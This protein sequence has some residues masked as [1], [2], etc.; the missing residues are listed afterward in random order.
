M[1]KH[2]IDDIAAQAKSGYESVQKSLDDFYDT[3]TGR[4]LIDAGVKVENNAKQAYHDCKVGTERVSSKYG[5]AT[6]DVWNLGDVELEHISKL[7]DR[8]ADTIDDSCPSLARKTR[9]AADGLASYKHDISTLYILP[10]D[11]L[12]ASSKEV[13]KNI[14]ERSAELEQ[15][16]IRDWD[17][18]GKHIMSGDYMTPSNVPSSAVL[19]DDDE[20]D[21][22]QD[23]SS[24]DSSYADMPEMFKTI[25]DTIGK[26]VE[27]GYNAG[28]KN[29][30][31]GTDDIAWIDLDTLPEFEL[32]RMS[33]M[34]ADFKE[35]T[36]A[37]PDN[38]ME[39]D[40]QLLSVYRTGAW[41]NKQISFTISNNVAVRQTK[42]QFSEKAN[43][44]SVFDL[45]NEQVGT[46][47]VAWL[48]DID[49]ASRTLRDWADWVA[50]IRHEDTARK[51]RLTNDD[52]A[53][54]RQE[55]RACWHW[56]GMHIFD[57]WW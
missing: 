47:F 7:L 46:D 20:T 31:K 8:Y 13:H 54:L 42:N 23:S 38:Y 45:T 30:Q 24:A 5:Y 18:I 52:M 48:E 50:T 17:W 53:P 22:Q 4:Q 39:D 2:F 55:F 37:S 19:L 57:L 1:F 12:H 29:V 34:L 35:G 56:I 16:F 10:G 15:D 44:E 25:N 43:I 14:D 49:Y 11:R 36:I 41:K 26:Y 32:R 9:H 21:E 40:T 51:T 33:A 27:K 28:K 3:E 6:Q